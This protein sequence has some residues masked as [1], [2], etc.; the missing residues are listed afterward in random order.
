[1]VAEILQAQSIFIEPDL[2][3]KASMIV[4][5]DIA[6]SVSSSP[7]CFVSLHDVSVDCEVHNDLRTRICTGNSSNQVFILQNISTVFQPGRLCLVLGPPNSG[8]S[9]LL[10]LVS[11]RL[12][13]NLRTTG[14]VLYNGKEL[15]DDFARS[16][17]GYVPQDD[18]HYPVLTVAETLRFAA[19]SML[20]NESEE[21]VEERL[22]KVL[23][24]FDLVGC[25]DTRVGNHESRG[26][27]GGEKKRL[28]CA[29]QMI[30]DHPVVCMDEISTGLDSAVTQKIISGLRDLCYDKRMTVIVSLLQP[31]IEIYNMFDDLLLLSATGRLLYHG[32]TNQAASYFDTQGFACPEYFEFSH[33]LVSL[34]TL[35]AREVLKRNSIF[36]GLTSCDELSQAWSSSEYMSEVINPLFEVVEVRKTSEEHDLEHER[37]SYTRPLV[38]LWKMFWLNLYR[39]RDVLIRDPVFVKQ[40]CIQ[41][42][43]QGIMLGTIFWNEQQHYLKISVLFI[44]STMVMM[45]NLA[46]VEIVAAK[47]RIYC[48]HRNCNLFFTSI[49]GV[50]EALTEVPLHAVE[51]IAFSFTFYFF[52][53]FY[54]QSFPVFLL[55]IFVAIV[56]YT[57][58]WKCVAAAFRNRSIAM[59]VV[60]SICTLSFC[61][62]GFLITKDSFPSFLGWIYWIF[63]FPFVLRA[64]AINE[65]SSS[66][67]SGQYDMI[68]NDHIH[69]AARWGDIFLIASGIPV[70]KIW[71]GACFIY[72]GSLFALFIFLYT[73]SLER[74]RFSRRAGSSLQTLLS[75][76]KGC[77]QLEAQFCEGNRSFDNAL[78][79]LGHPQLQTMACSLAIKNLGFTLQSQPPPSSSSS[80]SS[81]MLQRYPVLLRD[82]NAIFRPGTV[83]A[84]MGSSGA[85]KTTLLDVLA[86]RKTTGKTSGD[87]LVNGH[88]REM[89]SFSRLC[90]YVE[91]ENMQFPYATVRESLLFSASLRLDSSVSEEERERMVEAVIDLIELRPIL[92]EVIDLEQTSLT[93]EQ[94]KRLSIA[95]EMIANPSILFLDEPTSGLDSRSVRRVMNTIRRIASCGKTV[96]CT[97]HQPSSE[98]FSMFDELLLLNHGGVAFYGDLGP[99]KESTR[100]K[101]TYRS[102]GNVVSFFEQLSE[103]V[104]KLEAGQ[105]P[106]DYILQVTSSG[107][108]TGRSIDF[109]EEYNRSA[110][111]QENLRRL[112]ELPPSDKLDL[113]QRSASTL[114]QLAV[115]ST[116]WFRYHWR[117]V[118]YNRTR[119]IIAIFVSLL[120]SLNIKHLLLPRVEDEASL[121]TF[122]GCL[123]AGFFFLCAGQVILSIG[124]FGD[125][126]MVF[127]KEQSVSMYSPAVHLISETIA[128][129]PWIIAILIIHMI[130]FYPLA[131]LSPQPHVLGNHILAMFLSLLM[132]TSLGQMISVLLPSTRTAFLASGFSLGLLN[133]Y[134]TFFLPVSFF[135]WPWRIFAYII[136]TQFC[137][138]ATM[139]NQLFCSVSCIPDFDQP[140][141]SCQ[142]H[143]GEPSAVHSLDGMGGEGP[144]CSI[145]E[146]R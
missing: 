6:L 98:V 115:C 23:T 39:H 68:I 125:T 31:S 111:K 74:Q 55:C 50:T 27:S 141:V 91:Q 112:D 109:V 51:A 58:A 114:R 3:T 44:A 119:I 57:T 144:G 52:I 122:E 95:V 146:D 116:R 126:M 2:K 64:L 130:V 16:M 108:E 49:Y 132:F 67:K 46:M 105:N 7:D 135:P 69:P 56:M 128:E 85:G 37:G 87:I 36:E 107:S 92:D 32:P 29:E 5:N 19:K 71:I 34:C 136:P 90:G 96:I 8:K 127:Y 38:S 66:G 28:T 121:Q 86:G 123:F 40:R 104:P 63:P 41:M 11:K 110:L 100:T 73:V 10:R 117:N 79:V 4:P 138:R 80:S 20:H 65:F 12:D 140:S 30:V 106:A 9:T 133:L 94:R 139:P 142:H 60:L 22:N 88:P 47:K 48:I 131:N 70:D 53:G 72:V 26:I 76:E 113:Q 97:I 120:F 42:S 124:V 101:R 78:S 25:K 137:L 54:P 45:G 134:S 61:Y 102:A 103:R 24:L 93:N 89:A 1:M 145:I 13:D 81:S 17:I 35:D 83:T 118:T 43:F 15:S 82:I 62:S 59:T 84:L 18:I 75:R 129:V 33:F 143:Q 77:M 21:E 14:Q 99:T